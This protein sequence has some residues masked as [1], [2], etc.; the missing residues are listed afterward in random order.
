MN[1]T[2]LKQGA[3]KVDVAVLGD[4]VAAISPPRPP[5]TSEDSSDLWEDSSTFLEG[6]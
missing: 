6:A 4:F 5:S 3:E 1:R 2:D